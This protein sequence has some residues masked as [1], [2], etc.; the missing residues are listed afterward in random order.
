MQHNNKFS[1]WLGG[2]AVVCA[3]VLSIM[4]STNLWAEEDSILAIVNDDIITMSD[5]RDYLTA[6]YFQLKSDGRNN[7]QI[8]AIMK[9]M[10]IDGIKKLV[11]DHLILS[12]AK[13]KGMEIRQDAI[14]KRIEDIKKQYSSEQ[15]FFNAIMKDGFTVTDLRRK[16]EDQ[17]KVKYLVEDE[18]KSKIFVNPQEVTNYYKE[19]FEEFQ[20]PERT[21]LDSIYIPI[22][23]DAHA[24]RLRIEEALNEI[25]RGKDFLEV[26]KSYSKAPS[27][28]MMAKGQML[29]KIEEVVFKLNAGDIS[30][31]V[32][33][34]NGF[35]IFKVKGKFPMEIASLEQTKE[36]IYDYLFQQKFQEKFSSWIHKLK[37]D[38]F[39]E[40][41]Q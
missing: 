37:K 15:D 39:V 18:V 28:G 36:E 24:A 7:S 40:I 23:K 6:V 13:K 22:A 11:E 34:P 5:L 14:N 27:M 31:V 4:P 8:E 1:I 12:E 33:V 35:Y 10:E 3:V 16:I 20:K 29:P 21:E 30:S 9:N 2:M 19:H 41:K 26:A 32:E 17:F 38:A 25:N